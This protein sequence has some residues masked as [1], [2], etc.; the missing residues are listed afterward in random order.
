MCLVAGRK[1]S[2]RSRRCAAPCPVARATAGFDALLFDCDGVIAETEELH[3]LA[4]NE[5]FAEFG[6][7]VIWSVADY[8]ML[9][10]ALGGGKAKMHWY[11]GKN[12]WPVS[13]FG[14]SPEGEKA[15]HDFVDSLQE[16]KVEIFQGYIEDGKAQPR[17]GIIE[18]IDQA[19]Q[20]PDLKT[21]IC[22]ASTKEGVTKLLKSVLG[23]ERL[24]RF[25][26][27]LL[28]DDVPKKKP[29]PLIYNLASERLAVPASACVVVEDSKIGLE[30]ALAASM[31]CYIVVTAS[32]KDQ[33]FTGAM[34]ILDNATTLSER[35]F[36]DG[37]SEAVK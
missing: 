2:R 1:A 12:G 27:L 26:L 16:R 18:L 24:G 19:L 7:G 4:Y 35:L 29:D 34:A 20:R 9:Q 3:R 15:Q 23:E 36:P 14:P 31:R 13:K 11:F 37:P 30:A 33:D 22:S 10:N 28:G 8:D 17:L 5:T 21:A 25:D 32:T 6:T